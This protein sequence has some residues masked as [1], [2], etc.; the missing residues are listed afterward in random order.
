[1]VEDALAFGQNISISPEFI[2]AECNS[3]IIAENNSWIKDALKSA[4]IYFSG[5]IN[6][7]LEK[8]YEVD[9]AP[10]IF[11]SKQSGRA[12]ANNIGNLE[13]ILLYNDFSGFQHE[14]YHIYGARDYYYPDELKETAKSIFNETIMLSISAS[15]DDLTVYNLGW[16]NIPSA[17]ALEFLSK[18]SHIS[19]QDIVEELSK[20]WYT[21]YV[22]DWVTENGV[23][24]GDLKEGLFDGYGIHK[25]NNGDVYEGNWKGGIMDGYG[26]HK[27][28]NGDVYEGNWKGGIMDGYG[29]FK[30]NNGDVYEG[31]WKGGIM[32]GYG[33]Y[34]YSNG[35]VCEGNWEK[36][37]FIG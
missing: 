36:G 34:T 10:V 15:L 8:K 17:K 4:E 22:T 31:N 24:E 11:V 32:D 16:T 2:V 18:T 29:I 30:C 21:G 23:Y 7:S 14:F 3:I 1:V 5:N 12:H 26:I 25:C 19:N 20:Q 37:K 28:N 27:C 9:E 35:S 13:Y 33:I 6:D